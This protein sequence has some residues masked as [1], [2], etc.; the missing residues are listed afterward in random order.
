[1]RFNRLGRRHFITLL[2]GAATAWPL[3]A[4][5]QQP[6][7][8]V[9]GFLSS[10]SSVQSV[11]FVAAFRHSLSETGYI[12]GHNVAIEYRWADGQY[13]RLPAL[14]ADLVRRQVAVMV[15]IGGEPSPQV[16]KAAT[17]T[18]PIVFTGQGD[19]VTLGLVA[20]LN[21]PGGN[22]T[23]VTLSGPMLVA[24][25]LELMREL[26]P[27][28]A[29]IAML[30]NPDNPTNEPEAR[31]GQAA[32]LALGQQLFVVRAK[33]DREVDVAFATMVEH[34]AGA[35]LVG[36]DQFFNDRRNQVI[37]LAAR[38]AIPAIYFLRVFAEAGGLISYGNS[39][40][41][42][43]RQ[44]GVYTGRI[45]KGEKPAD[46]P[47]VQPT[48]FETV[49]N[50]KTAKALGLEPPTSILLRADEVIE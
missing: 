23:G 41:D 6:A 48:K 16:A 31:N 25:R 12:E 46:L 2:G 49:L 10:R 29:V 20:S 5:A 47:V 35:L 24:K 26:V 45:L 14:A 50:L 21:R 9:V 17:Q 43:Y 32:A 7:M 18:I 40:T 8:P 33:S 11:D 44:A 27:K 4:R 37:S 42:L 28:A 22:V 19:P 30:I 36:S 38:Y 3:A 15:A 13:D 34:Q 1:M 39:L